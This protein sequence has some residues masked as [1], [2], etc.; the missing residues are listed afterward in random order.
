GLN[1]PLAMANKTGG[2]IIVGIS[3]SGKI[4]GIEIGK[5]TVEKLT[6]KITQNTDPTVYPKISIA[7]MDSKNVIVI[8]VSESQDHLVLAF[9]RPYKRV[10]KST[11]KMSKEEYERAILE[12]RI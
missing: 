10:G 9:G 7:T 5:D 4:I 1:S 6:N 11:I 8:E 12:N 2:K 3:S